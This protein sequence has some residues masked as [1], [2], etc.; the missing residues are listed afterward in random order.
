MSTTDVDG[1]PEKNKDQRCLRR[2]MPQPCA[3]AESVSDPAL[4]S[5]TQRKHSNMSLLLSDTEGY[6]TTKHKHQKK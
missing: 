5:N 4:S 2:T 3:L 1:Q 6:P